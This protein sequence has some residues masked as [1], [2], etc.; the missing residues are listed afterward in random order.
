MVFLP[1]MVPEE[2]KAL[3]LSKSRKFQAPALVKMLKRFLNAVRFIL[4][5]KSTF[6]GDTDIL[7]T[8]K[9]RLAVFI[10]LSYYRKFYQVDS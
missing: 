6:I 9:G 10:A 7:I 3:Q 1:R 2:K 8:G 4:K 5:A